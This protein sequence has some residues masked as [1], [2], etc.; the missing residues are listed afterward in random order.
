VRTQYRQALA[1]LVESWN[2]ACAADDAAKMEEIRLRVDSMLPETSFAAD[3]LE[4]MKTCTP[5]GCVQMNSS[6]AMA[7]LRNRVDP[8]FASILVTQLNMTKVTVR[9]KAR[10]NEKGD[11]TASELQSGNPILYP[12]IREAIQQWK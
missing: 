10:I 7:R 8:H 2:R 12:A 11:V 5:A 3:I 9:V 1:S 4:K 6:L